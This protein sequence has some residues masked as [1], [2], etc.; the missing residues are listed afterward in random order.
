MSARRLP[1][2]LVLLIVAAA[3]QG[4]L[5]VAAGGAVVGATGAVVG[6]TGK[7]VVATGKAVIPGESKKDREKREFKEWKKS[8]RGG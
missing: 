2:A 7:V 8:Q 1:L 6:T 5:A 3:S 4:C